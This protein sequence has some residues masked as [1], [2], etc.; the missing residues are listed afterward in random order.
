VHGGGSKALAKV[1]RDIPVTVD[2][3]N[4]VPIRPDD[5]TFEAP[6]TCSETATDTFEHDVDVL[7]TQRHLIDLSFNSAHGARLMAELAREIQQKKIADREL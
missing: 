4:F 2:Y 5:S 1:V 6:G 3:F 7:E